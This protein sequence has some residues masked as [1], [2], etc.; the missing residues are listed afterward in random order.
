MIKL[1][2]GTLNVRS[3]R[4]FHGKLTSAGGSI[5]ADHPVGWHPGMADWTL[6]LR[7]RAKI[8]QRLPLK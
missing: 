3:K 5:I 6:H 1:D 4:M 8:I 7:A 2:V